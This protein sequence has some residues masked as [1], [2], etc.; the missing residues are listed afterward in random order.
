MGKFKVG[1]RV[2]FIK[3]EGPGDPPIGVE[4][5][6]TERDFR[7]WGGDRPNLVKFDPPFD[8]HSGN[9]DD[10]DKRSWWVGD[11]AIEIVPVVTE[12]ARPFKVGDRVLVTLEEDEA[13][14]HD[15]PGIVIEDDGSNDYYSPYKIELFDSTKQGEKYFWVGS[16]ELTHAPLA[17]ITPP[18]TIR[19]FQ[20]IPATRENVLKELHRIAAEQKP[21]WNFGDEVK[22]ADEEVDEP[23]LGVVVSGPNQYDEYEVAVIV[24]EEAEVNV[25]DEDALSVA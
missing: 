12:A 20:E 13:D 25:F 18:G 11:G 3:R 14:Y 19:I 2:K 15:L 21:K 4:G 10:R 24:D 22:V 8:G 9:G 16:S 6:V 23:K 7:V 5:V 1:D 17:E